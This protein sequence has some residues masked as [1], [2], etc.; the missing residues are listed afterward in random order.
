MF[1]EQSLCFHIWQ[2]VD[3]VY[4]FVG[5]DWHKSWTAQFICEDCLKIKNVG[6]FRTEDEAETYFNKLVEAL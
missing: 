2:P 5:F 4:D 3:A 1:L 6:R